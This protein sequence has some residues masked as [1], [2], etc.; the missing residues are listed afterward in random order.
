MRG[1]RWGSLRDDERVAVAV[2]GW[3]VEAGHAT[4]PV[5]LHVPHASRVIPAD[6]RAGIVLD[7]EALGNE[8]LLMTDSFTDVIAARASEVA[9]LGPWRFVNAYSRLLVDPERFPDDREEMLAAGM[10]AVYSSTANGGVLRHP[11][12][13]VADDL[14]HR[15]FEPYARA[16]GELVHSRLASVGKV[17]ILDVHSFPSRALP[18]ELHR[19]LRRPAV[20]I[21]VDAFHTPRALA[22]AARLRFEDFGRVLENEPF[23]GTY[24]PLAHWG[25]ARNV[26]SMMIEIRRDLY[27]DEL[28]GTPRPESLSALGAA[29][30]DLCTFA[31][32]LPDFGG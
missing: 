7:E 32:D 2:E 15:Y 9:A 25:T 28:T 24:V 18:Y 11:D 12:P 3:H 21:G 30:G 17:T 19:D 27:M 8:L 20:C 29:L 26:S 22:D 5:I 13:A 6:D 10:G 23:V 14:I 16:L 31:V 4:S 1:I